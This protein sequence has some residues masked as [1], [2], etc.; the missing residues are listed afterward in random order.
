MR[1]LSCSILVSLA[2]NLSVTAASF[3]EDQI[4]A[5]ELAEELGFHTRKVIF[6]FDAPVYARADFVRVEKG[7]AVHLPMT[8]QTSRSEI[9]FYS[10]LRNTDPNTMSISFGIGEARIRNGFRYTF[11]PSGRVHNALLS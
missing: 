10:I 5:Q 9:P 2:F 8:T 4:T 11:N 1:L 6:T 3:H 7:Q